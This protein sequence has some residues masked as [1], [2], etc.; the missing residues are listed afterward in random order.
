M[1]KFFSYLPKGL[2]KRLVQG[3][4][5][6]RNPYCLGVRVLVRNADGAVLLV[7]HSYLPGWYLPGG[8]VDKGETMATAAARELVEEVGIR[9]SSPPKLLGVYLNRE[10]FGRDHI[11]FYEAV[12]WTETDD[13][14]QPN[15][16]ILEAGF[17]ALDQLPE[18]T[19]AATRRRL[20]ELA[21]GVL[22]A[23]EDGIW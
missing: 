17:F 10:A 9:C 8:G 6:L 20:S 19:T 12:S 2:T 22:G 3:Q 7:R 4:A 23:T 16:E 5:L 18:A 13:F 14:M 11:G 15:E 1:L 21:R